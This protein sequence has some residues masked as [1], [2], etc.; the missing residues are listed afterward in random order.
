MNHNLILM[1]KMK[2]IQKKK[3][4]FKI[5]TSYFSVDQLRRKESTKII[6]EN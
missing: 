6:Y 2:E 4:C 1:S 3:I 5:P